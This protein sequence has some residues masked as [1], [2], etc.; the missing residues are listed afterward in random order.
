MIELRIEKNR[1]EFF[2]MS[3]LAANDSLTISENIQ[4]QSLIT[5]KKV[6]GY[7]KQMLFKFSIQY[8]HHPIGMNQKLLMLLFCQNY[9]VLLNFLGICLVEYIQRL[10]YLDLN[11]LQ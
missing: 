3:A 7:L 5:N 10:L 8:I 2:K 11:Y 6:F 1:L 9:F 4:L